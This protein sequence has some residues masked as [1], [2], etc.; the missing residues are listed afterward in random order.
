MR[1]RSGR[2]AQVSRPGDTADTEKRGAA[3]TPRAVAVEGPWLS[4]GK[5]G[6][7]TV[8]TRVDGGLRRWTQV[9]PAGREWTGP[10]S[11][12]APP[13]SHLSVAQGV[14]GF[15]R[16]L[17]RRVSR[18]GGAAAVVQATQFQT[19]RPVTE[20]K[21]VGNPHNGA[22]SAGRMGAPV[23]AVSGSGRVHTFVT[24]AGGGVSMRREGPNGAWEPWRDL[25]G[26]GAR[27]GMVASSLAS[28]RIELFVPGTGSVMRWRQAEP[29]GA[30]DRCPDLQI[31]VGPGS[32]RGLETAPDR[33]TYYWA[34]A[35]TGAL[36][37][38]RPGSWVIPLGGGQ[39]DG[40]VAALRTWLDGYD[41]TVLAHRGL[42]GQ[43]MIAACG[44]ENE[45]GG[46][47]WSPT[48]EKAAGS[49][50][51]ACDAEGR[52]VLAMIGDDGAL[53]IARQTDE[54]GL[55]MAPSVRV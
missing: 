34:D 51:L 32:A 47:W 25:Q 15:V 54:A 12:S 40:R 13:L 48:G 22:G 46:L 3:S 10:D 23:V 21:V 49:P 35:G 28:G 45:G 38:H 41:C 16:L 5:D 19:G 29:D 50:A 20:W 55:A 6:R 31:A 11:F 2:A 14:D 8:F 33:V 7:L 44:T 42:D 24:N 18:E 39:V 52:V 9:R 30:M 43:I 1:V 53:R 36:V 37:A 17:G 27:E 26:S 4:M